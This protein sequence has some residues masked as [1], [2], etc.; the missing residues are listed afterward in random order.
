MSFMNLRIRAGITVAALLGAY[1]VVP[2]AFAQTSIKDPNPPKYSV[3]IEPKLNIDSGY[4]YWGG[5]G[6]GPG[7][8]FSIPVMSPGFVKTI[9]DSIAISFGLDLIHY[10]GWNSYYYCNRGACYNGYSGPDLWGM[11]LPVA[12]QWNFWFNEH[13]SAFGE[14]GL[15][16]RHGFWSD[17][18]CYNGGPY[19]GSHTDIVPAL[20]AGGRFKFNDKLGLTMRLGYPTLFSIGLSIFI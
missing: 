11:V 18:Y 15:A 2:S 14:P 4:G 6:F 5:T 17:N 20:Y 9:N 3:E 7:V 19:C 13:W 8:R 10:D 1:A 16:I 12:M